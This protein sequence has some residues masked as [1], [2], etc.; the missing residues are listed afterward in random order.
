MNPADAIDLSRVAAWMDETG[1]PS[2]PISN[3]V[4]LTGGTQNLLLAFDKGGQRFVLRQPPLHSVA[5]GDQTTRR[6]VRVLGAL[7][8]TDVPHARLVAACWDPKVSGAAFFLMEAIDGFNVGV[9]MPALHAGD[10]RIRRRMGLSIV[11][12]LAAIGRVDHV[13]VDLADFGKPQ[14]FLERQVERWRAQF[15]DYSRYDGWPGP[16]GLPGVDIIGRWLDDHRPAGFKPGLMHGDFHIKNV[17]YRHGSGDLAAVIDWELATIGDPM[18]DLGWLLATWPGHNGDYT[19]AQIE[20]WDGF[21]SGEE[22]IAHYAA[23]TGRDM[24]SVLWYQVFACY[25]LALILEGTFA[26]ACAG[27][28]PRETGERLHGN[29]L[30]LLARAERWLQA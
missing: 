25:K 4:E 27:K 15:E 17:L 28:A 5:G 3:A 30:R 13:A 19:V 8:R 21:P 24:R 10:P 22:L 9:G 29:A 14:G 11:E 7:A 16:S 6:E 1:L 2:G 23:L 12:A 20:P 26:R 18:V